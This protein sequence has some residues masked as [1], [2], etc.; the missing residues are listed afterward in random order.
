MPEYKKKIKNLVAVGWKVKGFYGLVTIGTQLFG[1]KEFLKKP[2]KIRNLVA[3]GWKLKSFMPHG[4]QLLWY[5]ATLF[6]DMLLAIN[7]KK[8]NLV[9]VGWKLK[10][11]PEFHY[12]EGSN[13]FFLKHT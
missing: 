4:V 5:H 6:L 10:W 9:A 8:K 7:N 11:E 2:N 12:L 1:Q 13:Y 3:V